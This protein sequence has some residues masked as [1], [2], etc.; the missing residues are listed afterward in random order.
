MTYVMNKEDKLNWALA[1]GHLVAVD[2][3]DKNIGV[4][5]HDNKG[6]E[7]FNGIVTIDEL[8]SALNQ[9]GWDGWDCDIKHVVVEDFRLNKER[10]R[11][12]VRM[13]T[14]EVIGAMR[15]FASF[16]HADFIRQAPADRKVAALHAGIELPSGHTPD[17]L[18]A[19]LHA[20]YALEKLGVLKATNPILR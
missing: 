18:S 20:I 3:G 14:S 8:L 15:L 17:D 11:G 9:D 2:P 12:G 16:C 13:S 1:R 6:G 19:K 4:S 10:N 5:V 7:L